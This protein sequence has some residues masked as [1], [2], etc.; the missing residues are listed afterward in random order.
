MSK[1]LEYVE[2]IR[3][4]WLLV[5]SVRSFWLSICPFSLTYTKG[6]IGFV[7][8]QIVSIFA[9]FPKPV[10]PLGVIAFHAVL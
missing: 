9:G 10:G 5:V 1:L 8:S 4:L 2:P 6:M 3:K 7:K